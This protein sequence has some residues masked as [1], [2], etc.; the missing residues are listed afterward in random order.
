M[1]VHI[2]GLAD[3]GTCRLTV[4]RQAISGSCRC[5]ACS[6][7]RTLVAL[8]FSNSPP[9]PKVATRHNHCHCHLPTFLPSDASAPPQAFALDSSRQ[10]ASGFLHLSSDSS[11][12]DSSILSGKLVRFTIA[13]RDDCAYLLFH[14]PHQ[15]LFVRL[16]VAGRLIP[17]TSKQVTCQA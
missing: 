6:T 8:S 2:C 1:R 12:K 7:G 17:V 5:L 11:S 16:R 10:T 3:V 13:T 9:T 14:L 15:T 4:D